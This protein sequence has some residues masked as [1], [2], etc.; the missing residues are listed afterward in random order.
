MLLRLFDDTSDIRDS[1]MK[2]H[3]SHRNSNV[4]EEEADEPVKA[5]DEEANAEEGGMSIDEPVAE[6]KEDEGGHGGG[7]DGCG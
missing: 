4:D 7:V 6:A 5:E 3:H 2:N 1:T